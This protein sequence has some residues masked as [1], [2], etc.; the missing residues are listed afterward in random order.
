MN[1]RILFFLSFLVFSL[2]FGA[3]QSQNVP[4][5]KYCGSDSMTQVAMQQYPDY[6][7]NRK[8]F[9]DFIKSLNNQ[10]IARLNASPN[11]TIP[12]VVHI[13]HTYGAD[14]ISD[15][16]VHDAVRIINEDFS[17]SNPDTSQVIAAFQ[18]RYANVGFEFKLAKKD[19]NGDC[20]TGITR[21]YS[22]LTNKADDNVKALIGWDPTKYL[23]IWVVNTISFGAGGYSYYPCGVPQSIEGVVVLNTQFGSIGRSNGGN[24][25]A[26]TLTHEIGHY[27]GL[28]HV[29]GGTNDPGLAG[30]C[31]SDD[32]IA[33]TPNT[34]GTTGFSCNLNAN[35]CGGV[36]G[37]P[38]PDGTL[39]DNVQN[40]MDYSSCARMFTNG[41]KAVMVGALTMFCRSNLV[42]QANLVA[43][44]TNTGFTASCKPI[45]DFHTYTDRICEGTAVSFSDHSYNTLSSTGQTYLWSF[46]GGTPSSSTLQNPVVT[47]NTAGVYDV[48]LTTTNAIGSTT[49]TKQGS[50]KVKRAVSTVGLP[51][52][53]GFESASFPVDPSNPEMDWE[54]IKP[55]TVGWERTLVAPA[56]GTS[57]ARVR[58]PNLAKGTVNT[59]IT[60]GINLTNATGATLK[61]KVASAQKTSASADRLA[62]YISKDCGNTWVI[63]YNKA[64]STLA[65]NNGVLINGSFNPGPSDYRQETV[66]LAPGFI[67]PNTLFK[68]EAT[69]DQGNSLFLDDIEINGQ[70]SGVSE[71]KA[72][73]ANFNVYPNPSHGEAT[74]SFVLPAVSDYTL[75]VYTL[76][77]QQIGKSLNSKNKSGNQ[78]I[79]LNAVTGQQQL[80]AGV[81]LVKLSAN[82]F[83]TQKKAIVF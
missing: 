80:P 38:D 44:G 61:F 53:Y 35:S 49:T 29:W 2:S 27:M 77:G 15:A 71:E 1:K 19:P 43:T 50:I 4:F 65:T 24:F 82:G 21:T 30:N 56:T 76:T 37:N 39:P 52:F 72:L 81:Y 9:N 17:K 14:N 33:D 31:G 70:I 10:S 69:S 13:V 8:V 75:E 40:Y 67:G 23:N 34:I 16:Q 79:K 73:E 63:R 12:I 3:A 20:T 60:P 47:Y 57:S 74:V 25:A 28:P 51:F 5:R 32:G 68:F 64:G 59:L 11:F 7:R 36:N 46:P 42:T 54:I 62:V 18:S 66:I 48:T 55:G 41:Q 78:E 45:A 22:A 83:T 6:A 26:R 58:N